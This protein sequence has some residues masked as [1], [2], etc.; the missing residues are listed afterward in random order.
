MKP[1]ASLVNLRPS[2]IGLGSFADA[3]IGSAEGFHRLVHGQSPGP[4]ATV[5]PGPG[6]STLPLSATARGRNVALAPAPGLKSYA[7]VVGVGICAG[8]QVRPS[9]ET[10]TAA[11]LPP[12]LSIAWPVTVTRVPLASVEPAE[13]KSTADVGAC[14]SAD[15][16]AGTSIVPSA[17]GC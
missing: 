16:D 14:V 8:C 6:V 9:V 1:S 2:S 7:Q 5:T 17:P 11:T 4:I 10:S 3:T 13:G 15:G 12:P